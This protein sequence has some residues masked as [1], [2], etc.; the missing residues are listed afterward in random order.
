VSSKT[1]RESTRH[2][3]KIRFSPYLWVGRL[4]MAN[5]TLHA[6]AETIANVVDPDGGFCWLAYKSIAERSKHV[7]DSAVEKAIPVLVK[8][9]VVRKVVGQERLDVLDRAGAAYN[10]KQPPTVLELLIPASAYSSEDLA[11]I[12]A[13]RADRRLPLIT[14]E[15]RP[16]IT[17][18]IGELPKTRSDKGKKSPNRSPKDRQQ[19]A[20]EFAE[21]QPTLYAIQDLEG[22]PLD[23]IEGDTPPSLR[24]TTPI[25]MT[26]AM[27]TPLPFRP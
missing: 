7:S 13:M 16:D 15:S 17:G 6:I 2:K 4:D 8:H 26:P 27:L 10:P 21:Q 3:Y 25:R 5:P 20:K 1:P 23:P 22:P 18:L 19:A 11:K 12:N 24:G 9:K 14:P